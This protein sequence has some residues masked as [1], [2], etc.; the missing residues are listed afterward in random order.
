MGKTNKSRDFINGTLF[1]G[2]SSSGSTSTTLEVL[3]LDNIVFYGDSD[4][5]GAGFAAS[6]TIDVSRDG[7]NFS[8]FRG[9]VNESGA[10]IS[11]VTLATAGSEV[12]SMRELGGVHTIRFNLTLANVN[13]STTVNLFYSSRSED[14]YF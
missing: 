12:F 11:G 8:T 2:V 14:A 9:I 5:G 10:I 6:I 4:T 13:A 7:T 1:S 3:K